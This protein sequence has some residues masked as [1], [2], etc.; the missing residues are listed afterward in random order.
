MTESN[1]NSSLRFFDSRR[2]LAALVSPLAAVGC[3]SPR[4]IARQLDAADFL[5]KPFRLDE[6]LST[7][8]RVPNSASAHGNA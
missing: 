7:I 1:E 5:K 8:D 2:L 4:T 3:G 6:L